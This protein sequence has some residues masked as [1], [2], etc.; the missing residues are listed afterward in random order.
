LAPATVV[1]LLGHV[2]RPEPG[3]QRPSF[4][5]RADRCPD[6]EAGDLRRRGG[7][8]ELPDHLPQRGGAASLAD[9]DRLA[10]GEFSADPGDV[11]YM[12]TARNASVG[13][14]QKVTVAI[15]STSSNM[16]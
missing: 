4:G 11:L 9:D 8:G 12:P 6:G 2:E 3:V 1:R 16:R 7:A 10:R 14:A 5:G 15:G 13:F